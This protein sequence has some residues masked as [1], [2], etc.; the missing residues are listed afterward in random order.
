M[1]GISS[2]LICKVISGYRISS[3]DSDYRRYLLLEELLEESAPVMSKQAFNESEQDVRD[4]EIA[5]E[6]GNE[7][8]LKGGSG[9]SSGVSRMFKDMLED[10]LPGGFFRWEPYAQKLSDNFYR[11][12]YAQFKDLVPKII[13]QKLKDFNI[14][15]SEGTI[16]TDPETMNKVIMDSL[17]YLHNNPEMIKDGLARA[18][19]RKEGE[20]NRGVGIADAFFVPRVDEGVL[21]E[22]L[23]TEGG[24][25]V[26]VGDADDE[27]LSNL[28]D[29]GEVKWR[30]AK[31]KS[32]DEYGILHFNLPELYGSREFTVKVPSEIQYIKPGEYTFKVKDVKDSR[33]AVLEFKEQHESIRSN[34]LS[35]IEEN[36]LGEDQLRA[37]INNGVINRYRSVLRALPAEQLVE[38]FLGTFSIGGNQINSV[39]DLSGLSE[40]GEDGK[41]KGS[42]ARGKEKVE[43]KYQESV[44]REREKLRAMMQRWEGAPEIAK[45]FMKMNEDDGSRIA[46]LV[47]S[48]FPLVSPKGVPSMDSIFATQPVVEM[49]LKY[50][51]SPHMPLAG[52]G[53]SAPWVH[54]AWE[55]F[56]KMAVKDSSVRQSMEQM[57]R[58]K[59]KDVNPGLPVSDTEI[60]T[61]LSSLKNVNVSFAR[62]KEKIA[63]AVTAAKGSPELKK[64]FDRRETFQA[65]I[66]DTLTM[67]VEKFVD[68]NGLSL[69]RPEDVKKIDQFRDKFIQN[70]IKTMSKNASQELMM[71][72]LVGRVINNL[73]MHAAN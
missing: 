32:I 48:Q 54:Y 19:R 57:V 70:T 18:F 5:R 64:F 22:R 25:E 26:K 50:I 61:M 31:G 1:S 15:R 4:Q 38:E 41:E 60:T 30:T 8:K 35:S 55:A 42:K 34:E 72:G 53:K 40:Y 7:E 37:F 17:I 16:E 29:R 20:E 71:H 66:R 27:V 14:A 62:L 59:R 65:Y 39:D 69:D 45:H 28:K 49:V 13:S 52:G 12:A 46:R 73:V 21:A 36:G 6:K 47:G 2:D 58:N 44:G 51:M 3:D 10:Y 33:G 68:E 56:Q 9:V 24:E 11:M 63:D 23:K 67:A 43:E